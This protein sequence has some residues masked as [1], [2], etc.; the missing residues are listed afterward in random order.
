[1]LRILGAWFTYITHSCFL[2]PPDMQYFPTLTPQMC[3]IQLDLL[4]SKVGWFKL[5]LIAWTANI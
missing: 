2:V 3:N 5:S 4:T 1:M